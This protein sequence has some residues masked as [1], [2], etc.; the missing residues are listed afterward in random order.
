MMRTSPDTPAMASE[1]PSQIPRRTFLRRSAIGVIG[2]GLATALAP[3]RVDAQAPGKPRLAMVKHAGATDDRGTGHPD[4][5]KQMVD[6][7]I[8]ELTGKDA[9][10]DAW[11]EFVAPDDVVGIKI[12]TRGGKFLSTQPCVIDAITAG[13]MAAGVKANNIIVWDVWTREL[14]AAGYTLNVSDQGVRCYATDRGT[15][16]G[17]DELNQNTV[18]DMLKPFYSATPVPLADKEVYF[19][20][21]L[22]DDVTAVINAPLIKDHSITGV[23]CSMKNH[24]GSIMNPADLHG[25]LCDP[26]IAALNA[27]GPIKDKTRLILVDGLRGLYN[28]GPHDRPQWRWTPNAI[29]AAT[30]PVAVDALAL[31]ILEEKRKEKGMASVARRAKCLATAAEMGLGTNDLA[32]VD[33]REIDLSAAG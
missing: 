14:V 30:D 26:Y 10:G 11:R 25:G 33:L 22:A 18:K 20:K 9:L 29:I 13:L 23:T 1:R 16:T 6:R 5:A 12:N 8:R 19:T 3:R 27:A 28:G 32:Q 24:Y 2:A 17:G 31:A 21:I 4:V 7:A 15:Y